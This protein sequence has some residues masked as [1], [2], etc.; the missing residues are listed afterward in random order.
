MG[1]IRADAAVDRSWGG[2]RR[3]LAL[4]LTLLLVATLAAAALGGGV[5]QAQEAST[6][7]EVNGTITDTD[8]AGV[9]DLC[10]SA[11][12]TDEASGTRYSESVQTDATG[13]FEITLTLPGSQ[14]TAAGTLTIHDC[15]WDGR[16]E[17]QQA[18]VVLGAAV[19]GWY[20]E[21]VVHDA[22]S[23]MVVDKTA[24]RGAYVTLE[25]Q[26]PQGERLEACDRQYGPMSPAPDSHVLNIA[27]CE[28]YADGYFGDT[29]NPEEAEP[30]TV[31]EGEVG[32]RTVVLQPQG[33]VQ[34]SIIDAATGEQPDTCVQVYERVGGVRGYASQRV[35]PNQ[36]S[37]GTFDLGVAA[38]DTYLEFDRCFDGADFAPAFPYVPQFYDDK[39]TIEQADAISVTAGQT[40]SGIDVALYRED[41]GAFPDVPSTHQF[42]DEISW[43]VGQGI[44]SGYPDGTFRPDTGVSRQAAMAFLYRMAGEP[45]GTYTN[46]F[47]DVP[48]GHDFHDEI[49]WGVQQGLTQGYPDGTFRPTVQVSRQAIAAFLYRYAEDS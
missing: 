43:L 6:D 37:D 31:E 18:Y 22:A 4:L 34:G 27:W 9:A 35:M 1:E 29:R 45:D 28:G 2:T 12:A 42:F 15:D 19:H 49:S 46:E 23:P 39:P 41:D 40:T 3:S 8:G 36:W 44:T 26:N 30:L 10:V 48:V 21:E 13:G 20:F 11:D 47:S 24:Y 7:F 5:S 33:R 32:T 17:A 25:A 16:V 38:G 14:Q